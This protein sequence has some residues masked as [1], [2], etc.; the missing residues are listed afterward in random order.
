[1][2]TWPVALATDCPL[3]FSVKVPLKICG[4]LM[5]DTL[6]VVELRVLPAPANTSTDAVFVT[7]TL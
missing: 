7:V 2:S 4:G 6:D 5:S 1:M 3:T